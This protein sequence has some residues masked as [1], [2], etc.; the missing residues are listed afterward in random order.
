MSYHT[1]INQSTRHIE[2][3]VIVIRPGLGRK[4][5]LEDSAASHQFAR[6][7]F[8]Y[9]SR[10]T[11][12]ERIDACTPAD[13]SLIT[14]SQLTRHVLSISRSSPP[15]RLHPRSSRIFVQHQYTDTM[16]SMDD[17]LVYLLYWP[18][19]IANQI[20]TGGSGPFYLVL[21]PVSIVISANI[22]LTDTRQPK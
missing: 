4:G 20:R 7:F 9:L 17:R 10:R 16:W 8:F 13:Y 19:V 12:R 14:L 15:S 18:T 3:I 6:N 1:S 21:V 5:R 22:S 2:A 11:R